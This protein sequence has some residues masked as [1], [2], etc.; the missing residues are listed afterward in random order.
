MRIFIYRNVTGIVMDSPSPKKTVP[1][2]CSF[3][4]QSGP[5]SFSGYLL[6]IL[7]NDWRVLYPPLLLEQLALLTFFIPLRRRVG[8]RLSPIR[9]RH[10]L[11]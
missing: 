3:L 10:D 7:F 8:R 6:L 4:V 1:L 5:P 2:L 9:S 11:L